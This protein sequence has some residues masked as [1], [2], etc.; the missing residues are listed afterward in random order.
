ML[1]KNPTFTDALN[2]A[3]TEKGVLVAQIGMTDDPGNPQRELYYSGQSLV[4][5]IDNLRGSGFSALTEYSEA[6]CAFMGPWT[7][8]AA[9]KSVDSVARWQ[10]S[11]AEVDL[12]IARRVS[13]PLRFFDGATMQGYQEASRIAE[14]VFCLSNPTPAHCELG[15]GFDPAIANDN[16]PGSYMD[17]ERAVHSAFVSPS[18]ISIIRSMFGS[19]WDALRTALEQWSTPTDGTGVLGLRLI[20]RYHPMDGRHPGY[21]TYTLRNPWILWSQFNK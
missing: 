17:L 8:L 7:Y 10:A 20:R 14:D 19:A 1:Y 13:Q 18:T 2:H 4:S 9:F 11:P 12:E 6:H 21:N 16:E 15:H 5:F 3:L